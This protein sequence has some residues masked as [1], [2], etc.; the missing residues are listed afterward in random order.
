MTHEE[1]LNDEL[2]YLKEKLSFFEKIK[3]TAMIYDFQ[4][5]ITKI[6]QKIKELNNLP[7]KVY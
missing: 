3:Y 4:R 2:E 6:E 7:E 5:R 1:D